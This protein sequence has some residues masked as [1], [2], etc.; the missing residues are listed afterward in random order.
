MRRFIP[1]NGHGLFD[2][3][4]EM[5][6]LGNKGILP[7]LEKSPVRFT[8]VD[9]RMLAENARNIDRERTVDINRYV[10][11][12]IFVIQLV[13]EVEQGLSAPESKCGNNHTA[14]PF[15]CFKENFLEFSLHVSDRLVHPVS[16]RAFHY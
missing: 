6:V 2:R 13:Q 15:E 1:V 5:N 7:F 12:G 14:A 8:I 16:I 9:F 4:D 10:H 3:L 11:G